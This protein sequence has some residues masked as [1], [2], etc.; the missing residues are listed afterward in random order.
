M[1][2]HAKLAVA[3]ICWEALAGL[4]SGFSFLW[5]GKSE[6]NIVCNQGGPP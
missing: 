2:T 5:L 6:G 3:N 1:R 4:W